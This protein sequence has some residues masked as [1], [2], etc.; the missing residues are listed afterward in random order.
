MH[1]H[2]QR[3]IFE[4]EKVLIDIIYKYTDSDGIRKI[5]ANRSLRFSRPREMNDPFDVYIDDLFGMDLREFLEESSAELFDFLANNPQQYAQRMQV[6]LDQAVK[7]SQL[8]KNTPEDRKEEI[9]R[10]LGKIDLTE[11]DS[12]FAST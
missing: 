5:L 2:L 8:I 3:K 1:I 12:T 4:V 6:D 9:K 10:T 11:F 7:I